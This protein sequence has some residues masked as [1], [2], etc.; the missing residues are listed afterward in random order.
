[1]PTALAV[2]ATNGF[3]Y[4]ADGTNN[5]V[6]YFNAD[7]L[8][9]DHHHGVLR[10]RRR[11]VSVGNDPVALA[12]ASGAGDLYV[13]NAGTGGGISVVSLGTHAVV[14]TISTTQPSNGTG[15][16]QSIGMSPDNQR[17]ARRAQRV[18]ASRAT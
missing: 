18:W 9:R 7:D 1:M 16:V 11:T 8:Q 2:D 12:V 14:K 3:V 17:G 10:A 13:A 4:V 5:R 6:E 15:L